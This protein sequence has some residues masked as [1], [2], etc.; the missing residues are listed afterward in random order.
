MSTTIANYIDR[1]HPMLRSGLIPAVFKYCTWT[2]FEL[3]SLN[4][5]NNSTLTEKVGLGEL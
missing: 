2:Q 4:L 3:S 1:H 5:S